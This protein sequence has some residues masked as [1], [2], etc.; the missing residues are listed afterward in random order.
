M[1]SINTIASPSPSFQY[2]YHWERII[3]AIALLLV[4]VGAVAWWLLASHSASQLT[5]PAPLAPK[6]EIAQAT[7]PTTTQVISTPLADVK[8]QA[9]PSVVAPAVSIQPEKPVVGTPASVVAKEIK[10]KEAQAPAKIQETKPSIQAAAP[11]GI[12]P[13]QIRVS[14][15]T[16]THVSLMQ[17]LDEEPVE[18]PKGSIFLSQNKAVKV[19]FAGSMGKPGDAVHYRWYHDGKEVAKIVTHVSPESTTHASKFISID[20]PGEW[21]V[22]MLDK[23]GKVLA[24]TAFLA[25]IR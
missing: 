10:P 23:H 2:V 22:Q 9:S 25:K 11:S 1:T 8:P 18:I 5:P 19:I 24:E 16:V 12:K 14:S 3:P 6:A 7:S 20:A 4:G 13:G 21:Q 17:V 15:D